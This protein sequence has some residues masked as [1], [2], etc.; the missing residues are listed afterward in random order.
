LSEQ[1]LHTDQKII[2]RFI[3]GDEQAFS[4]IYNQYHQSVYH[5]A[6]TYLRDEGLAEDVV[7]DSFIL[8]WK[9]RKNLGEVKDIGAY[10]YVIGR[11]RAVR[12][13]E[14]LENIRK[15]DQVVGMLQVN[16]QI[17]R[18]QDLPESTIKELVQ[19]ALQQISPQQRTVFE[20]NRLEGLSREEVADKMGLSKA[21]VNVHLTIALKK[22]RAFLV[23]R[24]EIL[25]VWWLFHF[26]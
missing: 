24:L 6:W 10:L 1:N 11:N 2:Q 14:N 7:Q 12:I 23:D 8:L 22:V 5:V 13:L 4:V 17:D 19:E 20:L 18:G 25:V 15:R 3:V 21:T 9:S 26:F 16:H